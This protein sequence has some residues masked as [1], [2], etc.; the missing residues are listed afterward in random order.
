[1]HSMCEE[2]GGDRQRGD[3]PRGGDPAHPKLEGDII[4]F[5]R[6]IELERIGV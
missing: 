4:D 3:G 5:C 6:E 1:M 2:E